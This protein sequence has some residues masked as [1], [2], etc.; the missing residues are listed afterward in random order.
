MRA[1]GPPLGR[2]YGLLALL[3][4][5][6]PPPC[7]SASPLL[8]SVVPSGPECSVARSPGCYGDGRLRIALVV[9]ST[10]RS[11]PSD[12]VTGFIN[13]LY[14]ARHGYD[15]LVGRCGVDTGRPY[16]WNDGDQRTIVW[17]KSLFLLRHLPAY[18][19][20]LFLDSARQPA[21]LRPSP[22]ISADAFRTGRV[23]SAARVQR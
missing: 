6:A 7:S 12:R 3:L 18:D 11:L 23:H 14:T 5:L 22:L 15:L 17:S 9:L 19:Y 13:E 8:S 10:T 21:L 1:P 4:V 2:L 20:L 16:L